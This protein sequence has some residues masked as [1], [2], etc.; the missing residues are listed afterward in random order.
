MAFRPDYGLTLLKRG[1]DK[2]FQ[3]HFYTLHFDHIAVVAK[4]QFTTL[5]TVMLNDQEHALTLDFDDDIL[6]DL[7]GKASPQTAALITSELRRDWFSPR[8]IDFP[9]HITCG[10]H[11]HL[12]EE[13]Q[14]AKE[15]FVPL[16]VSE[17]F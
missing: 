11:A 6:K 3:S 7:I 10:V 2:N 12:G 5:I 14:A 4:G 1:V 13:Q 15:V 16:V 8:A 17:V 9:D